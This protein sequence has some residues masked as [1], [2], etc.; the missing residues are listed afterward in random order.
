MLDTTRFAEPFHDA[1]AE[2]AKLERINQYEFYGIGRQI[3]RLT[4]STTDTP[5]KQ[6]WYEIYNARNE[7][8]KLVN[9]ELIPLGVSQ[10]RAKAVLDYLAGMVDR[11]L[12]KDDGAGGRTWSFPS[13]DD[14]VPQWEWQ[15]LRDMTSNFETVFSEEM[16]EAA[17]Y[18][19]P[20]RGI[21]STPKLVD[22]ADEAFPVALKPF[23]PEMTLVDWRAAGRCL[24]FNLLSASGFH[25]A[26]AVEATLE[27]YYQRFTGKT[28]SLNSWNDYIK[29][30][31]AIEETQTPRPSAKTIEEIKQMKSDY[32]NPLVHPRIVLSEGDARML[33]AN[34]ES[35]II[36]MSQELMEAADGL[37]PDLLAALPSAD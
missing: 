7:W 13:D 31:E 35:L 27:A 3:G 21:Y 26:R 22:H 29:A 20:N 10:S 11:H 1:F 15:A 17:T 4:Q 33:F 16:R 6:I 12:Y 9:G 30:L 36:G 14:I 2:G 23:I 18:R 8:A 19:V 37:Q 24:A 25:V 5:L 28:R 34:G 32:R